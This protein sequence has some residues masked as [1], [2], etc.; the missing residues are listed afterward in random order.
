MNRMTTETPRVKL[1]HGI[2]IQKKFLSAGHVQ[3]TEKLNYHFSHRKCLPLSRR[4]TGAAKYTEGRPI[5]ANDSSA[6]SVNSQNF[7]ILAV[8]AQKCT[9]PRSKTEGTFW[10][11]QESVISPSSIHAF[12]SSVVESEGV[13][14]ILTNVHL[15][16][17]AWFQHAVSKHLLH[18]FRSLPS[19]CCHLYSQVEA[20]RIH[21]CSSLRQELQKAVIR[22]ENP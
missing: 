7:C 18:S 1:G 3:S 8:Y 17:H 21:W 20:L 22:L 6:D 11:Q 9:C 2:A 4:I 13:V 5:Q 14:H 19:C 10:L 12:K 15:L 16:Y